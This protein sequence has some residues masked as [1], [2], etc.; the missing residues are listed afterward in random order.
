MENQL[1]VS[2]NEPSVRSR[3]QERPGSPDDW[4]PG[5]S[6]SE[7]KLINGMQSQRIDEGKK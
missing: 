6:E 7:H 4:P 2:T 3:F 5:V 1:S